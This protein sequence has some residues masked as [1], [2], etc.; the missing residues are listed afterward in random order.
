[1]YCVECNFSNSLALQYSKCN[2]NEQ[3]LKFVLMISYVIEII[4][5]IFVLFVISAA[6]LS[7]NSLGHN[8]YE[9]QL[10]ILGI[11]SQL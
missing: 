11:S 10:L 9:P 3:K 4:L 2:K 1:M 7:G 5:N 8:L 6:I